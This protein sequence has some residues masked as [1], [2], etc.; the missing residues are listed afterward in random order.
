MTV[1]IKFEPEKG[2]GLVAEGTLLLDA[3]KRLGVS[4]PT[5]CKGLGECDTCAVV[6]EHGASLLSPPTTAE[7]EQL[8][9]E[10]KAANQRLACQARVVNSGEMVVKLAPI[11][12]H[13]DTPEE[14][15]AKFRKEFRELP[16]GRKLTRLVE[17]EAV[18]AFETLTSIA[19]LPF[20]VGE[21]VLDKVAEYG[22]KNNKR[23]SK[24][25]EEN[26]TQN[27]T[28]EKPVRDTL[29]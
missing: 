22:R 17:F 5:E 8:S 4:I 2:S 27:E 15:A 10:R 26:R 7:L 9:A 28:E 14:A 23:D 12:E 6:V 3:A 16:L 19:S 29:E 24:A 20:T 13:V 1:H 11:I 18:T 25:N 21:K